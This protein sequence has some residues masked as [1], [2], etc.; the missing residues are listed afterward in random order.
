LLCLGQT[1]KA[2]SR[3]GD[4]FAL[5]ILQTPAILTAL[6]LEDSELSARLLRLMKPLVSLIAFGNVF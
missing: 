1:A 5:G 3:A 2:L 4:V 6:V